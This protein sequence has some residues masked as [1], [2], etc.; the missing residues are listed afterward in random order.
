MVRTCIEKV[1]ISTTSLSIYPLLPREWEQGPLITENL[2][3][4]VGYTLMLVVH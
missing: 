4:V 2:A 3:V 1:R